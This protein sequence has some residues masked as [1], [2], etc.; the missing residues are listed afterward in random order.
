MSIGICCIWHPLLWCRW[1]CVSS[2]TAVSRLWN[3]T[4]NEKHGSNLLELTFVFLSGTIISI[5]T[6]SDKNH[7]VYVIQYI[8][9]SFCGLSNPQLDSGNLKQKAKSYFSLP[10]AHLLYFSGKVVRVDIKL[11]PTYCSQCG[12]NAHYLVACNFT[13]RP[14]NGLS[15]LYSAR[16]H[17]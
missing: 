15:G 6:D 17:Q 3:W 10:G 1:W 9:R 5:C 2:K 4:L 8:E 16:S 11:L 12:A 13:F 7:C 14:I